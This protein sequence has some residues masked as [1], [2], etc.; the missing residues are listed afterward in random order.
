MT[1]KTIISAEDLIKNLDNETFIIFDC[2]C[3]IKESSYGIEAYKE[4]H[5]INSIF[6][7]VDHDLASEATVN[8][9]RHPLPDPEILS[10]KL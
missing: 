5:I 9:G 2:R 7:D 8:S 10:E 1:Y 4:G 6:V 3:D